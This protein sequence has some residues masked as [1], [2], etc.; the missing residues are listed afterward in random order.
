[1]VQNRENHLLQFNIVNGTRMRADLTDKRGFSLFYSRLSVE[2]VCEAI[3]ALFFVKLCN[4]T[5]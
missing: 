4:N 1:M 2:S 3:R 5:L